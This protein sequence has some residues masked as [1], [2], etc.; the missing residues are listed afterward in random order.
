ME[1]GWGRARWGR[2][3][4]VHVMIVNIICTYCSL[5]LQKLFNDFN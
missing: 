4:D 2:R 5:V 3:D 1:V